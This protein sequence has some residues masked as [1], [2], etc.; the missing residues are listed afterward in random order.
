[1]DACRASWKRFRVFNLLI[2]NAHPIHGSARD[3]NAKNSISINSNAILD[4]LNMHF[5]AAFV[6]AGF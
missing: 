5:C 1:L 4:A 3:D 6:A 2:D